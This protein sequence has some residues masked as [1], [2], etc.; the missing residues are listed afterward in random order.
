MQEDVLLNLCEQL[1]INMKKLGFR[2]TS[3]EAIESNKQFIEATD[4]EP[5]LQR[6][7]LTMLFFDYLV[8]H[9]TKPVP[10]HIRV[11]LNVAANPEF[12]LDDMITT[13]LPFMRA[14]ESD[15]FP[16]PESVH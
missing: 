4:K 16:I 12:W 13:V 1:I 14:N 2:Q 11:A 3:I 10:S 5:G 9:Q 8:I 7:M 6:T 15:F